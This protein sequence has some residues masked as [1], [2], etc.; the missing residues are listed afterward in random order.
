MKRKASGPAGDFEERCRFRV[1]CSRRKKRLAVAARDDNN[2]DGCVF[3]IIRKQKQAS[4]A[5]SRFLFE[6]LN[7]IVR[8]MFTLEE[9]AEFFLMEPFRSTYASQGIYLV[10]GPPAQNVGV[11]RF[12]GITQSMPLFC[13]DFVAAPLCFMYQHPTMLLRS[14]FKSLFLLHSETT[15]SEA[16]EVNDGQK[17]MIVVAASHEKLMSLANSCT[18]V[19][20][21]EA[22]SAMVYSSLRVVLP[23]F[24][25]NILMPELDKSEYNYYRV[26][27]VIVTCE[28]NPYSGEWLLAVKKDGLTWYSFE[29]E[30]VMRSSIFKKFSQWRLFLLG[31]GWRLEFTD[32]HDWMV[33]KALYKECFGRNFPIRVAKPIPADIS[34]YAESHSVIPFVDWP[35]N[36]ISAVNDDFSTVMTMKAANYDMDSEDE[37]WLRKFNKK[38]LRVSNDNFELIFYALEK[39][40]HLNPDDCVDA[41]SAANQCPQDLGTKDVLVA[42]SKYWTKKRKEKQK[43]TPLVRVSQ[44]PEPERAPP[45]GQHLRKRKSLRRPIRYGKGTYRGAWQD[46]EIAYEQ[47]ALKEIQKVEVLKA[48]ADEL[49]KLAMEK[50]KRAELLKQ[51]ADLALYKANELS[52]IAAEAAHARQED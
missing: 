14:M 3:S 31:N 21:S 9:L 22:N 33:F 7:Y 17:K 19:G 32:D 38:Y 27:G 52:R 10:E 29:A 5:F 6:A 4:G 8:L 25:A 39:A 49:E 40:F 13:L 23:Y 28:Q 12:F 50:R 34:G 42:V 46:R 16:I 45:F 20:P 41:K 30:K 18:T 2:N 48:L 51:K 43:R 44:N 37:K 15:V 1:V 24:Y 36:Y 47:N 26:G 11:C 35:S